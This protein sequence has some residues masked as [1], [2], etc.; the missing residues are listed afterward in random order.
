[1]ERTKPVRAFSARHALPIVLLLARLK[2]GSIFLVSGWLKFGYV[3]HDQLDTLYFLFEDYKVPFLP[4]HVAAWMGMAGELGFGLMITL[5]LC[6]R[7]GAL[8][9]I[10]MSAIIFHTDG[11]P[12]AAY[13]A[14][15]CAIIA[16]DGP[17]KW[18]LDGLICKYKTQGESA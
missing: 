14:L 3:L 1:M 18:S 2:I 12:A 10:F 6:G 16:A 11:N 5:G 13:W 17:G 7:L 9:L 8:G 4:T 15:I